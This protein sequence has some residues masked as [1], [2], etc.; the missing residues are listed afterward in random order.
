MKK[1]ILASCIVLLSACS[2][3]GGIIPQEREKTPDITS[4]YIEY[5][6]FF[7]NARKEKLDYPDFANKKCKDQ[8]NKGYKAYKV[9][10][11]MSGLWMVV[12]FTD[13]SRNVKIWCQ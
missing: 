8:G 11:F 13:I 9:S 6:E 7:N 5:G 2:S 1:I 10:A 4:R 3:T 12:P